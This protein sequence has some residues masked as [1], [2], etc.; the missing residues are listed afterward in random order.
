[1]NPF[2]VT[3]L[4]EDDGKTLTPE[5]SEVWRILCLEHKTNQH[6]I[7]FNELRDQGLTDADLNKILRAL[8]GEGFLKSI[9]GPFG[10]LDN[11]IVSKEYRPSKMKL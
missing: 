9:N 7:R 11:F 8:T 6:R 2:Q 10:A 4:F 5:A 1:L 3:N